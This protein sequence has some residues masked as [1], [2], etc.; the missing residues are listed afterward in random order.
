MTELVVVLIVLF[1]LFA[2]ALVFFAQRPRGDFNWPF[3]A[4]KPLTQPEQVLFHR[5]VKALPEC[6]ILAQ[7]QLSRVLGVKKGHNFGVWYNRINRLSVDYLVCLKDSTIVAAIELDDSS[8]SRADRVS[9]DTRKTMA[10][11]SAGV[12]L[13]RWSVSDIPSVEK[14]REV[15]G[16]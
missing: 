13:I 6:I 4:K 5:L 1:F 16:K 14:I 10:L 11:K 7:V 15:I 8:H 9:A 3:F 12:P 2:G